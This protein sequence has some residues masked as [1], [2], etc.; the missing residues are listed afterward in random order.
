MSKRTTVTVNNPDFHQHL[1]IQ[2][3]TKDAYRLLLCKPVLVM[4]EFC[5]TVAYIVISH[6]EGQDMDYR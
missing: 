3:V 2:V 1:Y 5:I 4:N 6:T